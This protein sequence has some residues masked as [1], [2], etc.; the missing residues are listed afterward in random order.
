MIAD[1]RP[2]KRSGFKFR[3]IVFPV[4]GIVLFLL[5]LIG[6]GELRLGDERINYFRAAAI[7]LELSRTEGD[8]LPVAEQLNHPDPVTQFDGILEIMRGE[9]AQRGID[10]LMAYLRSPRT[11]RNMKEM[12]V[13]ALGEMKAASALDLL[14]SLRASSNLDR[15]ELDKA[16]LKIRGEYGWRERIERQFE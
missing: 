2:K 10:A 7:R 12:A 13:W 9:D 16:I 14:V 8:N 1:D 15:Y 11:H 5:L 6:L 4:L 3:Y